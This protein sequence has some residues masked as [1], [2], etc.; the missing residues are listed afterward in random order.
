MATNKK[1]D[2]KTDEVKK[3]K[4]ETNKVKETVKKPKEVK[5]E[6]K[7]ESNNELF[8]PENMAKMFAMFKQFEQM[9]QKDD[10]VESSPTNKTELSNKFNK[11]MLTKIEDEVVTVKSAINNVI[12][13]SPKTQIKYKWNQ[14]GDVEVLSIKEILAMENKSK[15]FLHTPWLIVDDERVIEALEL[16]DLYNKIIKVENIDSLI[17]LSSNEIR[18]IFVSLPDNYKNNFRNE[19][20]MKVKTNELRDVVVINTLSDILG[21]NLME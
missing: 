12:F 20:Y 5:T 8:T 14:K 17:E 4:A 16:K 15:R 6:K 1:E 2:I 18:E 13:V 3:K 11:V 21:I 10:N 19:I 7:V 9:E